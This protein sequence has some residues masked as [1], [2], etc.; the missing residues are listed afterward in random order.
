MRVV[1]VGAGMFGAAAA[2]YLARAGADV[3]VIGPEQPGPGVVAPVQAFG[4][5]DDEARIV[6]RMGWDRVWGTLDTRSTDR[7]RALEAETGTSVFTECGALA[8][9]GAGARARAREMLRL[10]EGTD[11]VVRELSETQLRR[12]LPAL[13]L[14]PLAGGVDGLLEHEGAGYLNPRLLVRAQ[15]EL[16]VAAGAS[17]VRGHVT[18]VRRD[19]ATGRWSLRTGDGSPVEAERVLVTTGALVNQSGA[20]PAGCRLD[21]RAYTEPNLLFEVTGDQLERL[22]T[23][24]TV[25]VIDPEDTGEQN[26]SAY[27]LPPVRYPDGRWYLRIGPGMQ[28][29]VRELRTA[30]EMRSW[31][32]AQR[33]T[34]VQSRLLRTLAHQLLPG[35]RPAAVREACCVVDKT[36]TRY[37]YLGPLGGDETLT[38]AVGGN[39][40]GARGSDEIGRLAATTVLGQAWDFPLPREVFAPVPEPAR[41]DQDRPGYL[42][43]PYGLC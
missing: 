24:P 36:P 38:V 41:R 13:G 11:V 43:P 1:V 26:W 37:P 30:D 9:L 15:L 2:K 25:V 27:L 14:P 32:G 7:L 39:G 34:A 33:I 3:V 19:P 29:V 31:Y 42:V 5:H 4:S 10:V 21:L 17:L 12:E 16:A 8:V 20:L 18:A 22:R 35:L 28:P 40:H 6:R 23:L